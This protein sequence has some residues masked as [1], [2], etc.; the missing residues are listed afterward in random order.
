MVGH[1]TTGFTNP[2]DLFVPDLEVPGPVADHNFD[3]L[4]YK[5]EDLRWR[6]MTLPDLLAQE[7]YSYLQPEAGRKTKVMDGL[8]LLFIFAR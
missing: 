3:E 2:R 6:V 4:R 8:P 7:A 5:K 1:D